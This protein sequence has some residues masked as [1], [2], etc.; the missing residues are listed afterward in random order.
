MRKFISL[1]FSIALIVLLTA[2]SIGQ[3]V[4]FKLKESDSW[5][6]IEP[7]LARAKFEMPK[8]PRYVERSFTP[9]KGRDPIK[10]KLHMS[11]VDEGKISYL[12]SYHDLP[13]IPRQP[14]DVQST[15]E[16]A[17]MGSVMNVGGRILGEPEEIWYQNSNGPGRQFAY[18]FWQRIKEK[19]AGE[20]V[21]K[22]RDFVVYSRVYLMK[23]R[24]YQLSVIMSGDI[25]DKSDPKTKAN[26]ERF[27][28]SF[29]VVKPESDLPPLPRVQKQ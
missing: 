10:V 29:R 22:E 17:M 16:G 4:K 20:V 6:T 5:K 13:E 23:K 14:K 7:S 8:K 24:Q 18:Q 9:V 27:L 26:T 19:V 11:V 2:N 28:N 1:S 25:F 15:L 21:E 12:F 3:E